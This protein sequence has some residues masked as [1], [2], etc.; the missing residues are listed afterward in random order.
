MAGPRTHTKDA[1]IREVLT[2]P[3]G[4]KVDQYEETTSHVP[5]TADGDVTGVVADADPVTNA[6]LETLFGALRTDITMPK[7][8]ITADIKGLTK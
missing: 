1:S 6:F 8:D 2:K 7:K 4:K 5:L 3:V